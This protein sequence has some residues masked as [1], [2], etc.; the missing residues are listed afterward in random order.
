M[1]TYPHARDSFGNDVNIKDV[2]PAMRDSTE[3]FC[4]GCGRRMVAVINGDK[5]RHFRHYEE[6]DFNG[7]SYIH[8]RGKAVFKEVFDKNPTFIVEMNGRSICSHRY[9]CPIH[10]SERCSGPRTF[11]FDLK[12][13]YD[14]AELEVYQ[15]D[16]KVQPDVLLTSSKHPERRLFIEIYHTSACSQ[17]K[18]DTKERIIEIPVNSERDIKII[19]RGIIKE[20]ESIHFYNFQPVFEEVTRSAETAIMFLVHANGRVGF[21]T[22]TCSAFF[23]RKDV[24]LSHLRY[25][26]FANYSTLSSRKDFIRF[27]LSKAWDEGRIQRD[28]RLCKNLNSMTGEDGFDFFDSSCA[29]FD[30]NIPAGSNPERAISCPCFVLDLDNAGYG[31]VFQEFDTYWEFMPEIDNQFHE[32]CDSTEGEQLLYDIATEMDFA[33]EEFSDDEKK[34]I[35]SLFELFDEEGSIRLPRQYVAQAYALA[36]RRGRR[37]VTSILNNSKK[38]KYNIWGG[39][40]FGIELRLKEKGPES[41]I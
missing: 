17:D 31:D 25:G 36:Q 19:Q 3:F 39:V 32:R 1:I 5:E 24:D 33:H 40:G 14:R 4:W 37:V 34:Y 28:C 26:I 22:T 6:C 12:R 35:N 41:S 20:S 11:R 29:L 8:N 15:K 13:Y 21:D 7:E 2:T 30:D 9:E 38:N 10:N 16:L 18:I 27:C 23:P